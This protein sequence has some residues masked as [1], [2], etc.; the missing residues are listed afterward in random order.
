MDWVYQVHVLVLE[1]QGT[2]FIAQETSRH[3]LNNVHALWSVGHSVI[4]TPV[5]YLATV[6][7]CDTVVVVRQHPLHC[8]TAPEPPDLS[9]V[10][11]PALIEWHVHNYIY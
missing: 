8:H 7:G 11:A 4:I 2:E 10:P 9:A 5:H 3:R 1:E 6:G